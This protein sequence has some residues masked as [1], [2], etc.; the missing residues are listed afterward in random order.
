MQAHEIMKTDVIKVT[1]QESIRSVIGKFIEHQISGLPVVNDKNQLVAYISDGDIMRFIG[2][3]KD[4]IIDTFYY[5]NV[6]KGDDD[7]FEQRTQK[8]LDLNVMSIARKK[9]IKVAW[10]EEAENIAAVLGN[11]RIKKLPVEKDGVLV[12][13][14]S[15]GDVIRHSFKSLL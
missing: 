11:K 6:I 12:G 5:V 14:I 10:D 7:E 4:I 9:V 8:A 3:H 15:R 13:I 1:E 2:K